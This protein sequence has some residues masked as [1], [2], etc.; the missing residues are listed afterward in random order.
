MVYEIVC[1]KHY[2]DVGLCIEKNNKLE[3]KRVLSRASEY[4]SDR[5][6]GGVET[7]T[8]VKTG[9]F[10]S[11]EEWKNISYNKGTDQ[12]LSELGIEKKIE[13]E[14][15]NK[16]SEHFKYI[17][18]CLKNYETVMSGENAK[19]GWLNEEEEDIVEYFNFH[20]AKALMKEPYVNAEKIAKFILVA[21]GLSGDIK[22]K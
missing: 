7:V 10:L 19:Q 13:K 16:M 8:W 14:D 17:K 22:V 6:Y 3:P 5:E 11:K 15:K 21:K 12:I 4:S 18:E 1:T 9:V 2:H 20:L